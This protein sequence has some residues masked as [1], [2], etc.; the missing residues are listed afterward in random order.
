MVDIGNQIGALQPNTIRHGD[1]LAVMRNFMDDETIDMVITSPPYN[2]RNSSGNGAKSPCPSHYGASD[3][4]VKGKE[5]YTNKNPM[6]I[7]ALMKSG[8]SPRKPVSAERR[9]LDPNRR[10]PKRDRLMDDAYDG[11]SDDMPYDEYVSWQREVLTECMRVIKPTGA[12]FYNHKWRSQNKMLQDR[13]DILEGFPV[14]QIIIWDRQSGLNFNLNYF[15]PV[16]EVIYLIAKPEFKLLPKACHRTDIWRFLAERD[17]PHPAPFPVELPERCIRSAMTEG[18]VLDPFMGSGTTA[19]AAMNCG[20]DYIGIEK[21]LEY[22]ELACSRIA[23][24]SKQGRLA[25]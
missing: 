7:D 14:R 18:L 17:N 25:I 8:Y 16:Y 4:L 19:I 13:S 15:L 6:K 10:T 5:Y 20:V 21:S 11:H 24:A 2:L 22:V 3:N 12:I 23:D 9:R 1:C